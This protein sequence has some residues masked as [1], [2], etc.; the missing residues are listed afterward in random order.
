MSHTYVEELNPAELK[1]QI[2]KIQNQLIET[3]TFNNDS[4][5]YP[6]VVNLV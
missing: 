6:K 5:S 4:V 3:V 2:V 1:R